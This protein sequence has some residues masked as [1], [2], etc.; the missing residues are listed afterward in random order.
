MKIARYHSFLARRGSPWIAAVDV[1]VV[2]L[3]ATNCT[4]LWKQFKQGHVLD[5][6]TYEKALEGVQSNK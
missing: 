6:A 3:N 2:Q 4:D 5:E 1:N